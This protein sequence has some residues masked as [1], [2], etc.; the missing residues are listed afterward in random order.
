MNVSAPQPLLPDLLTRPTHFFEMLRALPPKRGRYVWLV[1]LTGLVTGIYLSLA[2][3]PIDEAL[4][5]GTLTLTGPLSFVFGVLTALVLVLGFWA[6][7]SFLSRLGAG[8]GARVGEVI[9]ATLLPNLIFGLAL[10]PLSLLLPAQIDIPVPDFPRLS[11]AEGLR[12]E[13]EYVAAVNAQASRQPFSIIS[14]VLG[15]LVFLWEA[16]LVFVGL[17]VIT[18]DRQ[19]AMRGTL[20]PTVVGLLLGGVVWLL[21]RAAGFV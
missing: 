15:L 20:I 10:I 9:G 18:G 6:L 2:Q 7:Q 16:Y 8:K 19:K 14:N 1:A 11:E 5:E 3:R 4:A 13:Q 17:N 12:A 21:G